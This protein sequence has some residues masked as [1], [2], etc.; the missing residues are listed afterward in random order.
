MREVEVS[1]LNISP[2]SIQLYRARGA[3]SL[4]RLIKA[5]SLALEC[6]QDCK[7]LSYPA[8]QDQKVHHQNASEGKKNSLN[9]QTLNLKRNKAHLLIT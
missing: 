1:S 8:C 4:D 9:L 2:R 5:K 7:K 6:R 3:G